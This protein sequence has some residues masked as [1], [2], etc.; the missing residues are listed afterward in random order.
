MYRICLPLIITG[1]SGVGKSS[2]CEFLQSQSWLYLEADQ[3]GRNGIDELRL[4]Q[5]WD[6]FW[7]GGN[8]RPLAG[9]L[10]RRMTEGN[11][12]AV[13]LSLPSGAIPSPELMQK[14]KDLLAIRILYADPRYC[15]RSFIERERRTGRG[16]SS[17]HW[18]QN[19]QEVFKKISTSSYHWLLVDV[20]EADGER[21]P[22]SEVLS[23]II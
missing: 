7:G 16:L 22:W 21:V 19:N 15:L 13:V 3:E 8:A 20:F 2:F 9:E 18:D 17:E 6:D 5:E 1:P 11:Y 14:A 12:N 4:R 10:K 23:K